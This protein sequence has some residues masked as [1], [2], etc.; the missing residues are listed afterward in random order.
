MQPRKPGI[1]GG[2]CTQPVRIDKYPIAEKAEAKIGKPVRPDDIVDAV[3]QALVAKRGCSGKRGGSEI[4]AA[5]F[6]PKRAWHHL[7]RL[8]KTIPAEHV[9]LLC[10]ITVHPYV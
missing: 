4:R 3:R 2:R 10:L 1:L 8:E 6:K 9:H 7:I 5:G